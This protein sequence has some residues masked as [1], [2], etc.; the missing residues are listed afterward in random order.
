MLM[1]ADKPLAAAL[2]SPS[3]VASVDGDRVASGIYSSRLGAQTYTSVPVDGTP[4][5][6]VIGLPSAELY[7]SIGGF[8]TVL[9]WI[10]LAVVA[11][12]AISLGLVLVRMARDRDALTDFSSQME[13]AARTDALTGLANRRRLSTAVAELSTSPPD[14]RIVSVLM[15][16]LD[17]FKPIN[18]TFGH[19]TGDEVLREMARSMHEVFR[20][21]DI[22]GRW[23]GD[24]FLAILPGVNGA[25][26]EVMAE[27]LRAAL[28]ASGFE[29][30]GEPVCL[31][32]SIGCASGCGSVAD[33]VRRA[34]E[35]LYLAKRAGGARVVRVDDGLSALRNN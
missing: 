19:G 26:A 1:S 29:A 9:A 17:K 4:W 22:W 35:A 32:A 3:A 27:R 11:L 24:E 33:L 30:V 15:M 7:S 25:Q 20:Q 12:L 34:D 13:R 10:I 31:D 23:G 28:R 14:G 6:L 21:G 2:G 8:N 5:R 16:D 18:D